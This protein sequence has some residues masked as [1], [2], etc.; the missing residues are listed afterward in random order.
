MRYEPGFVRTLRQQLD[1]LDDET[2]NRVS[3]SGGMSLVDLVARVCDVET[4]VMDVDQVK[5]SDLLEMQ[6]TKFFGGIVK[7]MELAKA[8]RVA[9]VILAGGAGTRVG[10]PKAL[11]RLPNLNMSLLGQKI[12]TSV[13]EGTQLPIFVMS[14]RD[15]FTDVCLQVAALAPCPPGMIFEQFESLRLQPDNTLTDPVEFY[16]TGHGDLGPALIESGALAEN[17]DIEYFC[18]SN[19]DNALGTPDSIL[20]TAHIESGADITY[21]VVERQKDDKGGIA[22]RVNDR[23]QVCESFQLDAE[24]V[25]EA[26]YHNTNNVII[27]RK[28]LES[29]V[30]WQWHRVR[31]QVGSRFVIQHERV[32]HQY[33]ELFNTQ[34]VLVDRAKRHLPIKEPADLDV[35]SKVLNANTR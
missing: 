19:V 7:T 29:S 24:F 13:M 26:K 25:K 30:P 14:S 28:V 6:D 21:E 20:L 12:M 10:G 32:L 5:S 8:G 31:K 35:A 33:S 3:R 16:P 17:P 9:S 2:K 23:L 22:A 11:L 27:N 4:P 34:F 1:S 15:I 18:V